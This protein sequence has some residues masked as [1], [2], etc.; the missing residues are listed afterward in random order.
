MKY[1]TRE[2]QFQE[3]QRKLDRNDKIINVLLGIAIICYSIGLLALIA[4][5]VL[6]LL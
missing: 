5:W 4:Q 2:E 1:T 6:I 3:I